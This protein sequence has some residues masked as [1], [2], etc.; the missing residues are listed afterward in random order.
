MRFLDYL[1][2]QSTSTEEL[3]TFKSV[4]INLVGAF[5]STG[6]EA[7]LESK[8]NQIQKRFPQTGAE[9]FVSLFA[10]LRNHVENHT[11]EGKLPLDD[12]LGSIME[13]LFGSRLLTIGGR[14]PTLDNFSVEELAAPHMFWVSKLVER[15]KQL[16]SDFPEHKINWMRMARIH[17]LSGVDDVALLGLAKS[18]LEDGFHC[19][20]FAEFVEWFVDSSKHFSGGK[21]KPESWLRVSA[22]TKSGE[23]R[24]DF[25]IGEIEGALELHPAHRS[26]IQATLNCKE[27]SV[28]DNA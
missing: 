28:S 24:R 19:M 13:R 18:Y 3:E 25:I 5:K 21:M 11:C 23:T 1:A 26:L 20:T 17:P 16:E 14:K 27:G 2:L 9:P 4:S 7:H 22:S 6:A 8:L 12:Y 15:Y 10:A